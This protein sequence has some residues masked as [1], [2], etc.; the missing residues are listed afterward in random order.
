MYIIELKAA[1]G[2]FFTQ[3][4]KNKGMPHVPHLVADEAEWQEAGWVVRPSEAEAAW[5]ASFGHMVGVACVC[6]SG[7]SLKEEK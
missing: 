1:I 4:R 2:L 5:F 6:G 3:Q 7:I